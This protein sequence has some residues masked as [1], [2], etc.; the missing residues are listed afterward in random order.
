MYTPGYIFSQFLNK[1]RNATVNQSAMDME[2][3]AAQVCAMW[4]AAGIIANR[5]E[6]EHCLRSIVGSGKK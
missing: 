5:L 2:A 3:K 6:A 4:D 1:S